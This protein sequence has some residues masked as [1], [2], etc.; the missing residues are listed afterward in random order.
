MQMYSYKQ[1]ANIF[2][3]NFESLYYAEASRRLQFALTIVLLYYF[4]D[5]SN[6]L[7]KSERFLR[8]GENM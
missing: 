2:T 4:Q 8:L 5:I 3:M 1:S 7:H 6:L